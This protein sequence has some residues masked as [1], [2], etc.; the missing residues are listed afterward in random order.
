VRITGRRTLV[1]SETADGSTFFIDGKPYDERRIDTEVRVGEAVVSRVTK[2]QDDVCPPS[3]RHI[4]DRKRAR[5]DNDLPRGAGSVPAPFTAI[6][7]GSGLWSN[8]N[9]VRP[10]LDGGS[11]LPELLDTTGGLTHRR[12]RLR[13]GRPRLGVVHL[14]EQLARADALAIDNP[15]RDDAPGHLRGNLDGGHDPH[16]AAGDHPLL[17]VSPMCDGRRNSRTAGPHRRDPGRDDEQ[18]G[19]CSRPGGGGCA[20]LRIAIRA[21]G[22]G[23]S[24]SDGDTVVNDGTAKN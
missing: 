8:R 18:T 7:E 10:G 6:A 1:F 11:D 5:G 22:S 13:H 2:F 21:P 15:D 24:N 17:E 16:P 23:R 12:L 3:R 14:H 9:D 19:R 20:S 4:G